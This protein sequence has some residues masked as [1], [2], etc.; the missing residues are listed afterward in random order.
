MYEAKT[1]PT[2]NSVAAYISRIADEERR[3][4]CREL[5]AL[6]KGITRCPP[7]LWGTGIVGFGRF[8]YVYDS[9]H[10]GDSCLVG[11][12]SGRAH[13]TLYLLAGFEAAETNVLLAQLGKHKTG[14]ACLYLKRLADVRRPILRKL[15]IRSVA[16][17]KRRVKHTKE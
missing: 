1:K 15:I 10:E 11:F 13:L 7:I 16:E 17:T 6:L 12:S 8:H 4:D 3:R 9:G 5:V 14:K 2:R